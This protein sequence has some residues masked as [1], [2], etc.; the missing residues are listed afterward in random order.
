MQSKKIKSGYILRLEKNE[1]II[2][3]ITEFCIKKNIYSGYIS[4]LGG[5]KN[6]NLYYYDLRKA[7]YVPKKFEKQGYE[8]IN[9][10]ANITLFN[11][12]PFIHAH[13]SLSDSKFRVYGGHLQSA[14]IAVTG[15]FYLT[16]LSEKISRKN[17]KEFSLN[18]LDLA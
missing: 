13:A 10:T 9:F 15:E 4:G 11:N 14:Q 5:I 17:N 16:T 1:E 3:T 12:K 6:V 18:F 7:R 2:N 8:M